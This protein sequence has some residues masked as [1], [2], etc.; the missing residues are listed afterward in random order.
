MRVVGAPLAVAVLLV[1]AAGC[2]GDDA[3]PKKGP[4]KTAPARSAKMA[5]TTVLAADLN[6][7]DFNRI[8]VASGLGKDLDAA[9]SVTLL[10]PSNAAL[11]TLGAGRVDELVADPD[12]AAAFVKS[13]TIDAG[14]SV[15]DLLNHDGPVTDASGTDW[16]VVVV[17][18]HPEVGGATLGPQD[19]QMRNGW[20]HVLGAPG[21]PTRS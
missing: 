13:H 6:Y 18:G 14:M 1:A 15:T 2:S 5:P 21:Q 7:S 11:A 20:L 19:I 8:V 10:V 9:K 16:K 4:S 12:A 3:T 17:D